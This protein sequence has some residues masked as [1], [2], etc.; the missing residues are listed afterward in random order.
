MQVR[1]LGYVGLQGPDP[2]RWLDFATNVCGLEPARSVPGDAVRPGAEGGNAIASDGTAYLK[3]DDWQWRIAVH[4]DERSGLRYFG[5]EVARRGGARERGQG[6]RA[7]GS[8]GRARDGA[9]ARGARRPRHALRRRSGRQPGRA[10]PRRDEGPGVPVAARR[11]ALRDGRARDGPPRADGP[12]SREGARLLL[13]RARLRPQRLRD[14]R[15]RHGRLVPALQ[16]A[17][18][19]DRPRPRRPGRGTP[20]HADRDAATSTTSAAPTTAPSPPASRSRPASAATPTTGC[21]PST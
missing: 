1:G 17:P 13:R 6:A 4:P 16:R 10:L 11:L 8:R 5:L 14:L 20:P 3:M 12:R 21:S 7:R 15:P 19:H 9:G 18:P 2:K